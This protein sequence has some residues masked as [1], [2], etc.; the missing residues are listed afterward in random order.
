MSD[1]PLVRAAGSRDSSFF[2]LK[3][4]KYNKFQYTF[5]KWINSPCIP[6]FLFSLSLFCP[7]SSHTRLSKGSFQWALSYPLQ[8]IRKLH[9]AHILSNNNLIISIPTFK[10]HTHKKKTKIKISNA[11]HCLWQALSA[12]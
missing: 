9:P 2:H 4:L 10:T 3:T 1:C 6:F 8:L 7:S 12:G 11:S 5:T